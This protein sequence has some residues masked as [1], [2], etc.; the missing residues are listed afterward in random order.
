VHLIITEYMI[1]T[2]RWN[3]QP[4]TSRQSSATP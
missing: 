3:C 2:R 1:Y 4:R